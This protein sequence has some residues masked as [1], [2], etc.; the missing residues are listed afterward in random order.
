VN[1]IEPDQEVHCPGNIEIE[2][3]LRAYMRWNAM[4]M[5]VKA[6]RHNPEDGGF[7]RA[8]WL[9]RII[10]PHVWCGL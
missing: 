8:H 5:V 4:A 10:G 6:N 7:G 9:L 2:E 3:R 1:T